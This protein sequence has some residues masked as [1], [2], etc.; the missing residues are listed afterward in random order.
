MAS[1][2]CDSLQNAFVRIYSFHPLVSHNKTE[3]ISRTRL[4]LQKAKKEFRQ[5]RPHTLQDRSIMTCLRML[6]LIRHD[7]MRKCLNKEGPSHRKA[8]CDKHYYRR[9][10]W[11]VLC[12]ILP[13]FSVQ[14]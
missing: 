8:P 2:F 6:M 1:D 12:P 11:Q 7:A 13:A 3:S 14:F 9:P 10:L 5:A 4:K